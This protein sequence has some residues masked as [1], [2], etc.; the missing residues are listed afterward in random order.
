M[1]QERGPTLR[2]EPAGQATVIRGSSYGGYN[3]EEQ[4]NEKP[5]SPSKDYDMPPALG[6]DPEVS[7][8]E[9]ILGSLTSFVG[10]TQDGAPYSSATVAPSNS[11]TSAPTIASDFYSSY[12]PGCGGLQPPLDSRYTSCQQ[13]PSIQP[14]AGFPQP[15]AGQPSGFQVLQRSNAE[16]LRRA[17]E[18]AIVGRGYSSQELLTPTPPQQ[19]WMSAQDDRVRN[20]AQASPLSMT[21]DLS[22]GSPLAKDLFLSSTDKEYANLDP[23]KRAPSSFAMPPRDAMNDA[24]AATLSHFDMRGMYMGS[25]HFQPGAN[26]AQY[27]RHM[28]TPGTT[29]KPYEDAYRHTPHMP[30]YRTLSQTTPSPADM[31][32]RVGMNM[33]PSLGLDKYYY[34]RDTMYRPQHLPSSPAAFMPQTSSSQSAYHERDYPRSQMYPQAPTY[35]FMGD[36]NYHLSSRK[37]PQ[38]MSGLDSRGMPADYFPGGP[39]PPQ[40]PTAPPQDAHLQDPYR[41]SVIYNM[42]LM[43]RYFE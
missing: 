8:R 3:K 21:P 39:P 10:R 1:I 29:P 41:R 31:F 24:A 26:P 34:P 15:P 13:P 6:K 42:N 17:S 11:S 33:N 23:N 37:L 16:L 14:P 12:L 30:D 28:S 38:T 25:G 35:P 22:S 5:P 9:S 2:Q 40:P 20:W 43:N 7:S 18:T 4:I 19:P 27:N 36:K 32:G